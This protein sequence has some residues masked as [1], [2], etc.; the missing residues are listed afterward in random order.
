MDV[1]LL[2]ESP[3]FRRLKETKVPPAKCDAD[4]SV[5]MHG[6]QYL[7]DETTGQKLQETSEGPQARVCIL[8]VNKS[9]RLVEIHRSG[10]KGKMWPV[11]ILKAGQRTLQ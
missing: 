7:V 9:H 2:V 8:F 1:E 5:K 3:K 6:Y 4:P 10:C 11:T